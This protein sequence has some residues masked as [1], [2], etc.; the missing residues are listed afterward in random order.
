MS[1]RYIDSGSSVFSPS[2][3]AVPVVVGHS[4]TSQAAWPAPEAEVASKPPVPKTRWK[5]LAIS[6]R[7]FNARSYSASW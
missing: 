3:K 5:S 6:R 7:T 1:F 4:S 2:L